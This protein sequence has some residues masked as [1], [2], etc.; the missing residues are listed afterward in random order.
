MKVLIVLNF[1]TDKPWGQLS[2]ESFSANIRRHAPDAETDVCRLASGENLPDYSQ[3]DLIVLS[4]GTFNL[5]SDVPLPWVEQALALIRQ[6]AKDS[7]GTKLLGL[8]WGHQAIQFALGGELDVLNKSNIGVETINLT[9]EGQKFFDGLSSLEIHKYHKRVV[10]EPAPGFKL[11]GSNNEILLSE[12]GNIM[13]FQGHPE[14]SSEILQNLLDSD[15]G[16]YVGNSTISSIT[17]PHDGLYIWGRLMK[18]VTT[19]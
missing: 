11:L 17:T 5:I 1:A 7:N 15:D 19:T 6:V 9:A 13:T 4:G 10:S 12:S 14:L 2:V 8:C 18:F 3:Y 16:S